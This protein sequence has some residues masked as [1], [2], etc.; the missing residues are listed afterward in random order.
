MLRIGTPEEAG[1]SASKVAYANTYAKQMVENNITPAEVIFVARKGIIVSHQAF[2]NLTP[3]ADSPLLTTN[4][5]FP[6][7]SITKVFTA[8][9]IMILAERGLIGLNRP[10]ADY[11][12]EF[13]GLGK[14]NVRIHHLLT[15]T[16]GMNPEDV[17]TYAR[18][19][20]SRAQVPPCEETEEPYFHEY[21][22]RR[23]AT[24]LSTKP[25][26]IMSYL[27]FG[28]DLLGEIVRR[29]SG[30]SYPDFV[31]QELFE[32]LGMNDS[33]FKVPH[34]ERHRIVKRSPEDP[35]AEWLETEEMIESVSPSAGIYSS[36]MDLAIFAQM[37]LNNGTYGDQR[38]LSPISI[39]EMTKNH[40]PGVSSVYRDEIFPEA[41]WGYGWSI[42]GSKKDGGDLFS[43]EA[44]S[45]WGAAGVFVAVD[46]VY[47]ILLIHFT[48]ERDLEKPFKNMY[49]DHFNNVMLAAIE[50]F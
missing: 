16:S 10:V 31:M 30:I 43:Q 34:A 45:H 18:G 3:A 29:V 4:A 22:H 35:C 19:E 48:I 23:Y 26:E 1:M 8:A 33:Y 11:I 6:L 32:P 41:S 14:E 47:D 24:P 13:Q 15:H 28:Y 12:P 27:G 50:Q 46:P 39:K 7:C 17:Y 20:G 2:G 5:L 44:Y 38:I 40:I 42:N 37:F 49:T 36:A 21:F 25:G 9:C